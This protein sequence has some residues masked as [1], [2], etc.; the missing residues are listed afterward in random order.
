M[1]S[2]N[3]YKNSANN[4]FLKQLRTSERKVWKTGFSFAKPLQNLFNKPIQNWRKVELHSVWVLK[5]SNHATIMYY[6][7][8]RKTNLQIF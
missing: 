2:P 1:F 4:Q 5:V 7:E 8:Q 6:Q 3:I